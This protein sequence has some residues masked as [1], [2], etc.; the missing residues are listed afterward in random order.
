[1]ASTVSLLNVGYR[2]T[3]Y[4]VLGQGQTRLLVDLGWPGS[5]GELTTSLKRKGLALRDLTHAFATHY[6]PDHAGLAQDLKRQG[7]RLIV[8]DTQVPAIAELSRLVKPGDGFNAI[9]L[10][11]AIIVSASES[12]ALL[13]TIGL[14]GVIVPTPGHSPDSMSLVLDSGEAFIGDLTPEALAYGDSEDVVRASWAALR[15]AGARMCHPGHG[16]ARPVPS[17]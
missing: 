6:H 16:P 1:M 14:A 9:T 12:R 13:A 10:D 17:P 15:R 7:V 3:N 5:A 8:I 2:S 11:D 4:Y